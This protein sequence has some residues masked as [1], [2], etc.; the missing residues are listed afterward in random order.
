MKKRLYNS[1]QTNN[2]EENHQELTRHHDDKFHI[3]TLHLYDEKK[4]RSNH[5]YTNTSSDC[6]TSTASTPAPM[7]EQELVPEENKQS[8]H[9]STAITRS[10][11]RE[12]FLKRK[13]SRS[14]DSPEDLPRPPPP[15][16][17]KVYPFSDSLISTVSPLIRNVI[18]IPPSAACLRRC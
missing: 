1:L 8:R 11:D 14:N 3:A 12:I 6:T 18:L 9:D 4:Q 17:G 5:L 13:R 16:P 10:S 2:L 15:S 7:D